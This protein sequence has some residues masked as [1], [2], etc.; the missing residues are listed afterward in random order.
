[1][2]FAIISY[3]SPPPVVIASTAKPK[4]THQYLCEHSP[5]ALLLLSPDEHGAILTSAKSSSQPL[6][7]APFRLDSAPPAYSDEAAVPAP[8]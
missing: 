2:D 7:P 1:V 3:L 8:V 6:F 5:S 4:N